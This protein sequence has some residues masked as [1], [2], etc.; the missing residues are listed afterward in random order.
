MGAIEESLVGRTLLGVDGQK[1][2]RINAI[3]VN[4][5][6]G[7]PEW[8]AVSTG[9]LFGAKVTFAPVAGVTPEGEDAVVT[10]DKK[11]VKQAPKAQTEGALSPAENDQLFR[12]YGIDRTEASGSQDSTRWGGR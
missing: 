5:T 10:F 4:S 8:V 6:T 12:Y 3:Y 11:H 2:G 9:G 7:E 1:I